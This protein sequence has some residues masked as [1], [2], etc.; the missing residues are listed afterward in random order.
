MPAVSNTSPLFNLAMIAQLHLVKEQFGEVWI[1][2]AVEQEFKPVAHLP[3]MRLFHDAID[4]KWL[5][6]VKVRNRQAVEALRL[7]LDQGE[8]EVIV[9]AQ[10]LKIGRV[11]IDEREARKVAKQMKLQPTGVLGILLRAKRERRLQSVEAAMKSL[12]EKAVFH[13]GSHLFRRI[14]FEAQEK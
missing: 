12:Q 8:S 13:I 2:S 11:L 1:P 7:E 3:Q 9:L 10:E 14:L 4:E 5:Q 6:I